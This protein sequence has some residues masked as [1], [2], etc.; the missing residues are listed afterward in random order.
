MND[1]VKLWILLGISI[2]DILIVIIFCSLYKKNPNEKSKIEVLTIILASVPLQSL[3]WM[4]IIGM[5]ILK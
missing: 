3:I 5:I 1:V 2:I 4:S